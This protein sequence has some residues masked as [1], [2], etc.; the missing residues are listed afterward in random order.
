MEKMGFNLNLAPVLDIKRFEDNHAI[1]DRAF[2]R[3]KE[4]VFENGLTYFKQ[5][6]KFQILP[7]VKHFPGHGATTKDSHFGIPIIK[8]KQ[9][10]L[11]EKEDEYPFQKMIQQG[12]NAILVGHLKIEGQTGGYPATMSRKFVVKQIRK[13]YHYT[14]IL[15]T[16]DMRMSAVRRR[17]GK[18]EA[19]KKAFHAG[20]DM[21]IIKGI[22]HD[23]VIR[24]IVDKVQGNPILEARVNR[25]ENRIVKAKEKKQIKD[26]EITFLEDLLENTNERVRE[27]RKKVGIEKQ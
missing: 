23:T 2:S 15:M 27:I 6:E 3:D 11:L 4:E 18:K 20:Y 25:R 10:E 8:G 7:V 16:D 22:E 26:I 19:V 1:G 21:I 24:E 17:Y 9:K 14:G 12:V 5:L 13:K